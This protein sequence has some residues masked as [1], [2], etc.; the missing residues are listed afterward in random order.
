MIH[1][2]AVVMVLI[3]AAALT[4]YMVRG[5]VNE[6]DIIGTWVADD[7]EDQSGFRCGKQGI[8]ATINNATRQY[9]SWETSRGRL[10]LHGKQ[11]DGNNIYDISDTIQIKR[12]NSSTL[13]GSCDGK[14]LSYKKIR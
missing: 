9:S 11:F 8:A 13:V 6:K 5:R 2:A 14:Q 1:S 12:L 10:I 3:V 4:V 7:G